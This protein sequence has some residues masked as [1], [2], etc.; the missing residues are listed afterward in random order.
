M[1]LWKEILIPLFA[2]YLL[3]SLPVGYVI[4]R[5]YGVDVRRIGSGR[6]GGT[7]VLRAAGLLPS[8]LTVL[9]D[10][11]KGV[12][13]VGLARMFVGGEVSAVA[14]GIAVVIGHN[15]SI[16]LGFKGGAGGITAA[17]VVTALNPLCGAIV[18]LLGIVAFVVGRMAS[19]ATLTVAILSPIAL[20]AYS[21]LFAGPMIHVVY[22]VAALAVIILALL[23]NI[24]RLAM[25]TERTVDLN[26]VSTQ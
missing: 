19:V 15:W 17:S 22:G 7:N 20:Y 5:L 13:A 14:A 23:P 1:I 4:G 12:I 10:A 25:G 21:I 6:T 26:H 8:A 16:F 24:K 2:G 9:G 3:G 18:A 11:M